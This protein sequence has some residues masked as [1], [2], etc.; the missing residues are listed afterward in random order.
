[1]AIDSPRSERCRLSGE[2]Y[3]ISAEERAF[4]E[5]MGVPVPTISPTERLRRLMA[6]RNAR[7]LYYRSCDHS[8]KRIFSQHHPDVP[9]PVYDVPIWWSDVWDATDFGRDI[10]FTRPFFDQLLELKNV[11][12]HMARFVINSTMENCDY[13]NCA[14][15][16]KNCYLISEADY[17]EDCFYSNRIYHCSDVVDCTNCYKC[18]VCYECVDCQTSQQLFFSE[19][20]RS[21]HDSYALY[22]CQSCADCIG[23]INQRQKQYMIFNQQYSKVEYEKKKAAMK[24]M[25]RS[26]IEQLLEAARSFFTTQPHRPLTEEF[27]ERCLGN[28]LYNSKN[29]HFCFD[30]KDLEDCRVCAR[31]AG[32]VKSAMNYVSWGFGAELIYFCASCGDSVYNLRFCSTCTTNVQNAT[33]C[34][35]CTGS[36]DIFGCIGLRNRTHCI[37]NKPYSAEDFERLSQKLVAHMKETGEWGEFF[38]IA[39]CSYSYDESIAMENFPL[40]R[41]AAESLGFSWREKS[42][43]TPAE[44][45]ADLPDSI[46]YATDSILDEQ[47][48]CTVSGRAFKFIPQEF[49]FLKK[50]KLPLPSISPRERH[51]ERYA[52]RNT[53]ALYQRRD[54]V[55]GE[56]YWT[57]FAPDAPQQVVSREKYERSVY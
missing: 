13:T 28:Y 44:N 7:T 4:C 12:P 5:R 53:Y 18:E 1:M 34:I 21:C 23:C 56:Q 22:D 54:P 8:G 30:C 6:E 17:D 49:R 14:G 9:F 39:L 26:G 19:H 43:I 57:S 31:C 32:G 40:D 46:E 48:S 35:L 55:S 11:V 50:W 15:Y 20:C 45:P 24:L 38:P 25:T 27:N 36:S 33:Y 37:L 29:S 47:F 51:A 42:A 16:M 10:D 3:E 41:G 2:S 52:R